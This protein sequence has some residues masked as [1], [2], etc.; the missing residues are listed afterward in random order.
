MK[1]VY[2]YPDTNEISFTYENGQC[3][4]IAESDESL[5]GFLDWMRKDW[6]ERGIDVST[7]PKPRG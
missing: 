5:E 3:V 7:L 6:Q 4:C 2:L 1:Y